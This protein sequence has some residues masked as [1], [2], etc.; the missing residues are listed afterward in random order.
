MVDLT[1]SLVSLLLP[2]AAGNF[3][4]VSL[5]DLMPELHKERRTKHTFIQFLV[6]LLGITIMASLLFLP[7]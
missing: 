5:T 1:G 3:I 2:F 6:M 4:Y 7:L